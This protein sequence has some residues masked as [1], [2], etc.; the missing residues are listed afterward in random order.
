MTAE[1]VK[2]TT[3]ETWRA[4]ILGIVVILAASLLWGIIALLV[5]L[6]VGMLRLTDVGNVVRILSLTVVPGS[7]LVGGILGYWIARAHPSPIGA[8]SVASVATATINPFFIWLVVT[9][10]STVPHGWVAAAISGAMLW[11]TAAPFW[12]TATLVLYRFVDKWLRSR[13]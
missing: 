1:L 4:S 8:A 12:F 6:N 10:P 11:L 9:R 3:M 5:L 7:V 2:R 13:F